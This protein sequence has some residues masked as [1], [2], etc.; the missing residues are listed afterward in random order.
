MIDQQRPR[1]HSEGASAPNEFLIVCLCAEWCGVCRDYRKGFQE[2]ARQFPVAGFCWLDI[3]S[4]ADQL[5]DIDVEDFP[6]LIIK[7][8]QLILFYGTMRPSPAHLER[9]LQAFLQQTAEQSR[10]YAY[11]SATRCDWQEDTD[12]RRIGPDRPGRITA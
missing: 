8:Q 1:E 11:S 2:V 9:T 12:L 6:T 7:R 4:D 10:Q 3:E 5:G